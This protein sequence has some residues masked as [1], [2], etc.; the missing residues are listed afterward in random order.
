MGGKDLEY[1]D[2]ITYTTVHG[3]RTYSVVSV[4]TISNTDWSDL[5]VT[6]P[7]ARPVSIMPISLLKFRIGFSFSGAASRSLF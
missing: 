7:R 2:T 6:S 3:T 5:Q 1:G 4:K